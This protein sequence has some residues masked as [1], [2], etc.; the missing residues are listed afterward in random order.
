MPY[1][2]HH[3]KSLIKQ[4]IKHLQFYQIKGSGF[5]GFLFWLETHVLRVWFVSNPY[6]LNQCC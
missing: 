5:A 3:G 1:I 4:T 6:H 2:T